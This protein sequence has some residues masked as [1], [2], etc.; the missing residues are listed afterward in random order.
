MQLIPGDT[1]TVSNS[2]RYIWY[3]IFWMC[4]CNHNNSTFI[5]CSTWLIGIGWLWSARYRPTRRRCRSPLKWCTRSRG[6]STTPRCSSWR[7]RRQT[8][9]RRRL[10]Y[11]AEKLSRYCITDKD[12][13]VNYGFSVVL[14]VHLILGGA[15]T[16]VWGF[17]N[18]FLRVPLACLS[19]L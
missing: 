18:N 6:T 8:Q 10:R 2:D 1:V 5:L 16:W 11:Y 14:Y 7:R 3:I 12:H 9:R 15:I 13:R 4:H 17:V 19:S